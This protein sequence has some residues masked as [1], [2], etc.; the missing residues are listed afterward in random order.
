MRPIR[1]EVKGFTAFRDGQT[2]EFGD[3]DLF[4]IS[5]PTGSGKSS[6]LDAITYALYGT[7]E[8][9]GKQAGQFVSQGQ[10]RMAVCFEFAVDGERWR[11]TRSTPAR[12][13]TK[14]LLEGWDGEWRQAGEGAD[15]VREADA[16]IRS[17]VGLDYDAFTRTVLLPQGRFA[18]FLVG[19]AKERRAILTDLLGLELFERLGRRAGEAKRDAEAE[20]RAKTTLLETEY[21]G[22]TPDAVAEAEA[23]AKEAA[24][25]EQALADAETGIRA[26]ASRWSDTARAIREVRGC[27]ADVADAATV[28][29]RAAEML[30]DLVERT[31]AADAFVA[32][33]RKAVAAAEKDI[34]KAEAA[35]TKA[36]E[37]W[38]RLLDLAR[39]R[40]RAE[41]LLDLREARAEAQAELDAALADVP[42]LEKAAA[43][44]TER[45]AVAAAD[46]EAALDALAE[47]EAAL[48][49]ARHADLVAAVRAGVHE[50]EDC[51]VCGARIASLPKAVRAL[52]VEKADAAREKA[53]AR[54]EAAA[55]ALQRAER[56]YDR[57]TAD[58]AAARKEVLRCEKAVAKAA[59]EADALAGSLAEAM[60]G[61][62]PPD[63]LGALDHRIERLEGLE[64]EARAAGLAVSDAREALTRAEREREGLT[65]GVAESRGRLESISVTALLERARSPAVP[66]IPA[67]KDPAVLAAGAAGLAEALASTAIALAEIAEDLEGGEESAIAEATGYLEGLLDVRE[68]TLDELIAAV[69]SARTAAA[70]A[71]ATA[72]DRAELLR[73]KLANAA[74][75]VEEVAEHRSRGDVFDALAKELRADRLIAFLQLEALQLLAAAGSTHL[76]TLSTGRYRLEF[77]ADEFYVVDTWNGEER[78]SARTL[79]GGETFLASLALALALS[80]QVRSLAVTEKARL[81]SL[82]LDEGF[83]TLDPE[84]LEVVVDAIEQLGGDGRLVG[85]ITHV[86]ELAIRLPAR[87]EVEKSPRGSTLR[88]VRDRAEL[89]R[90]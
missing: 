48:E 38:G 30:G 26:V 1:L 84:T 20:A 16:R 53:R 87:I 80:E 33:A 11:V 15:R 59:K 47:A 7:I 52:P 51:P 42:R 8:R 50:G 75:I 77:D 44:A 17:A 45:R 5:G 74:A 21:A 36:E 12:G 60:G 64:E 78:R 54:T 73:T 85:V 2:I 6:I 35:R 13:A 89:Q 66:A 9:V 40:A 69:A 25:R 81:D 34:R 83:G 68:A 29:G 3:L 58:V 39:V 4:A 67:A 86:Q 24:E 88:V 70:R 14:I 18:E 79:S 22:V 28:A 43:R 76:S 57:A 65:A 56:S 72:E 31:A 41:S 46:A 82:F 10:T 55:A 71:A 27:A 19:D 62:L 32:E 90:V 49:D 63:P 37:A 23:L 61:T